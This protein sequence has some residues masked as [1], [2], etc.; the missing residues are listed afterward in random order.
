MI[1]GG[2]IKDAFRLALGL[3]TLVTAVV[4][5]VYLAWSILGQT[6]DLMYTITFLMSIV[7]LMGLVVRYLA[8]R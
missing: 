7:V 6:D 8:C 5:G 3:S 2:G 1:G 4:G